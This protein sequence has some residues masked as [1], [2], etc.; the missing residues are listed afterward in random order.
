MTQHVDLRDDAAELVAVDHRQLQMPSDFS[1]AM[2]LRTVSSERAVTSFCWLRVCIIVAHGAE[3]GL[4]ASRKPFS[5][6]QSSLK[7]LER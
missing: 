6:I 7:I 5:R 4:G 3:R 1:V 2:T